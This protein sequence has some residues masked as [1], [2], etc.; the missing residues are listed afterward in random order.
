MILPDHPTP[1]AIRTHNSDPVPYMIFRKAW[2]GSGRGVDCVCEATAA[3]T[4]H[5]VA[6]G[7]DLMKK[8][9]SAVPQ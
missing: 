9:L 5:F 8:F 4:G 3:Q 2:Q 6:H 1:L 7:P